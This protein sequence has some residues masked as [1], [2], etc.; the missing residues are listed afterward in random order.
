MAWV[1]GVDATLKYTFKWMRPLEHP[2]ETTSRENSWEIKKEAS[3]SFEFA[4]A[5]FAT[6]KFTGSDCKLGL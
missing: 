1:R 2:K 6:G 4:R 3:D 5:Y